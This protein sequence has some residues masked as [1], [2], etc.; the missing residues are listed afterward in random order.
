[1]STYFDTGPIPEEFKSFETGEAFQR[2]SVCNAD[3]MVEGAHYFI[4]KA[5]RKEETVFEYAMCMDCF[6]K[7]REQLSVKS[8]QL[9]EHY[10][11]EHVDIEARRKTLIEKYGQRARSWISNCMIRHT[12]FSDC[13]EYQIYGWFIGKDI[14]YNGMPY[15]LSGDV[16]DEL[17]NLLS[18]ET[19]GVLDDFSEKLF[20]IDVPK[21]V[22]LI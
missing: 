8:R 2:C 17:F 22:I 4:E 13:N 21:G 6:Q 15:M 7:M 14:V 9:I 10:F 20:G 19:T 3:L 1:M 11:D 12:P 18:S 5:F 16:I